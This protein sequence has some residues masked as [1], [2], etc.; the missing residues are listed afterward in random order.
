VSESLIASL[1]EEKLAQQE[2][3]ALAA[4][5]HAS[6]RSSAAEAA[7][8]AQAR[9]ESREAELLASS[10]AAAEAHQAKLATMDK[11]IDTFMFLTSMHVRIRGS[12]GWAACK[13]VN[14][15]AGRIVE[16][17]VDVDAP[18]DAQVDYAP[19][20]INL[21]GVS[22]P[23][24]MMEGSEEE[25]NK[26]QQT[27]AANA[28]CT[29]DKLSRCLGFCLLTHF[30]FV[31][32]TFVR[33][34][35]DDSPDARST[36]ARLPPSCATSWHTCT[37]MSPRLRSNERALALFLSHF[38][39]FRSQPHATCVLSF[40]QAALLHWLPLAHLVYTALD[41]FPLFELSISSPVVD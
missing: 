9:F 27:G 7:S 24:W 34:V 10:A 31:R 12:N 40:V 33:L 18:D 8:A 6:L 39:L 23:S 3:I 38:F 20:H 22:F 1:R 4:S 32:P 30:C 41:F 25:N 29:L 17:D 2:S 5:Q 19:K 11:I 15:S 13:M 14:P 37:R 28:A 16:F 21:N 26:Q 36:R 35:C